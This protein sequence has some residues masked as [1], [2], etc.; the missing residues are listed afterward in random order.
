MGMGRQYA[1]AKSRGGV[2]LERFRCRPLLY[3]DSGSRASVSAK[4][5]EDTGVLAFA[6]FVPVALNRDGRKS[7]RDLM[8]K[9]GIQWDVC[10]S[11]GD[12]AERAGRRQHTRETDRRFAAATAFLVW[13]SDVDS[14][15]SL[16]CHR[17]CRNWLPVTTAA[18]AG[19]F[20]GTKQD[21]YP[22]SPGLPGDVRE[23]AE[24]HLDRWAD[25]CEWAEGECDRLGVDGDAE[26]DAVASWAMDMARETGELPATM[27]DLATWV[28]GR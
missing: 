9:L 11:Y 20:D 26:R 17:Y 14:L 2:P 12:M 25:A 5:D 1:G 23:T 4:R 18:G 28:A 8:D 24:G 27:E 13:S 16:R 7:L 21:R 15:G 22:F 19:A 10:E 6:V 3:G